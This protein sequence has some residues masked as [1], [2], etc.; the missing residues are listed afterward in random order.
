MNIASP[1][2]VKELLEKYSV[3]PLKRF[4]QNFLTDANIADK[5]AEAA[6][7]EGAFALEIGPG[8]GSLTQRLARRCRYVAAYEIDSGLVRA[9]N[10]TFKDENNLK[11]IHGDFLKADIDKQVPALLS[12]DIYVAANLP[13]YVTTDCIM[14]L[15]VSGLAIKTI[16]VMVQKEFAERLLASPGSAEYG[17]L[18]A[19]VSFFADTE[20]LFDVSPSCFFPAPHVGSTVIRLKMRGADITEARD[21]LFTVKSLFAARRKTVKSNLKQLGLSG[22][23]AEAVLRDAGIDENARAETLDMAE[24]QKISE[25][26]KKIY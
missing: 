23:Q 24:F 21:Y 25:N 8:L 13:Y 7:P 6:V 14:K 16:T 20:T 10:S 2:A 9:L 18:N 11:V 22:E 19:A 5:I 12:G 1:G 3:A 15:L 17:A 26:L 4:G